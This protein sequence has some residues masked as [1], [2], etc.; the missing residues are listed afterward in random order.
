MKIQIHATFH[1]TGN[2]GSRP[3]ATTATSSSTAAVNE[4]VNMYTT[5]MVENGWA[6]VLIQDIP[7]SK[8]SLMGE[9]LQGH[10]D[11]LRRVRREHRRRRRQQRPTP[12]GGGGDGTPLPTG[13]SVYPSSPPPQ[14]EAECCLFTDKRIILSE[15]PP[16]QETAD[17]SS[18]NSSNN[19]YYCFRVLEVHHKGYKINLLTHTMVEWN[20]LHVDWNDWVLQQHVR[21]FL[22]VPWFPMLMDPQQ[23]GVPPIPASSPLYEAGSGAVEWGGLPAVPCPKE[24][25]G[26]S[27]PQ[28]CTERRNKILRLAMTRLDRA[29]TARVAVA[30]EADR[31]GQSSLSPWSSHDPTGRLCSPEDND[32]HC[33]WW[34]EHDVLYF[35][36]NGKHFCQCLEVVNVRTLLTYMPPQFERDAIHMQSH[37]W[38]IVQEQQ[39]QQQQ[40]S[41]PPVPF[42]TRR[43]RDSSTTMEPKGTPTGLSSIQYSHGVEHSSPQERPTHSPSRPPML[44]PRSTGTPTTPGTRIQ[45][46]AGDRTRFGSPLPLSSSQPPTPQQQQQQLQHQESGFHYRVVRHHDR[47]DHHH[48]AHN[49]YY[50]E[51][52][53]HSSLLLPRAPPYLSLSPTTMTPSPSSTYHGIE[54]HAG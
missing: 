9:W 2:T 17:H 30:L 52:T 51:P 41:R 54:Y 40:A 37:R 7:R 23:Q 29:T 33:R 46:N 15:R 11:R 16:Q 8:V 21:L 49:S 27:S 32:D 47:Q 25:E 14:E 12:S 24:E 20:A 13:G 43:P 36:E 34:T 10:I 31:G 44:L 38:R 35:L 45:T 50:Q 5:G 18:S 53:Y 4:R 19:E 1:P 22:V 3:P 48:D 39:Q 6:E 28:S 42:S 26:S